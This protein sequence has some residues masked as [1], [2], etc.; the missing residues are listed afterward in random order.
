MT[1]K[2]IAKKT[3]A[4]TAAPS[5]EQLAMLKDQF[6]AEQGFTRSFYPRLGMVSQDITEE[7][8]D[9]KTGKKKIELITEAGMFFTEKQD[10][11]E[12][13]E[14]GNP[15][16]NREELG[17]EIEATIVFQRKQLKYF[18]SDTKEFTSSP[19][20]DDENDIVPLFLNKK[21]IAR[22]T[23]KELMAREEYV[24][25]KDGK[26][27]SKL[28]Y[29]RVLYVLFQGEIFQ[30]N[31][32]GSS[33]YSFMTYAR[34]TTPPAVLTKFTSEAMENGSLNWNKMNFENVRDLTA[35]EVD[36]V[37][38][39]MASIKEKVLEEKT[40][41]A[42]KAEGSEDDE[43]TKKAQEAFDKM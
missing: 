24:F 29:N 41:F 25:V 13:D 23:P 37:L 6:P 17:N 22:G 14:K 27:K 1:T 15:V 33:M 19:I 10:P 18:N 38:S 8:K 11:E 36:E 20:F 21:E 34:K 5:E 43:A 26:T 16:W 3:T 2:V 4:V 9:P 7:K 28:E 40:F 31:L 35:A 39:Q 42:N 12:K 30:L 32:R